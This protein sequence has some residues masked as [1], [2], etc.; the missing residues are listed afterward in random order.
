L[1][2]GV[3]VVVVFGGEGEESGFGGVDGFTPEFEMPVREGAVVFVYCC[4]FDDDG[5]GS[6]AGF[7]P[8]K[9]LVY[10]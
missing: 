1:D 3:I 5:P 4:V 10:M 8:V 7:T 6:Y 9:W 2:V